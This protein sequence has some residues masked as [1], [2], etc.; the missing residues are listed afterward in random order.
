MGEI[1][2]GGNTFVHVDHSS[3]VRAELRSRYSDAVQAGMDLLSKDSPNT[4]QPVAGFVD[5]LVGRSNNGWAYSLWI[6]G[7]HCREFDSAPTGS[8]EIALSK[9]QRAP[10]MS[11]LESEL[12][13]LQAENRRL[14]A[15]A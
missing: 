12:A 7:R 4:L 11:A 14:K 13:Q 9:A 8:M 3:D 6:D 1:L 2:S 10:D 5:V 15:H